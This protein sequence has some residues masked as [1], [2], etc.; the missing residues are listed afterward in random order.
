MLYVKKSSAE[1]DILQF[2]AK[3]CGLSEYEICENDSEQIWC[4]KPVMK[5]GKNDYVAS[6]PSI[7]RHIAKSNGFRNLLG[8][9]GTESRSIRRR[10][11]KPANISLVR[12]YRLVR[13][14]LSGLD[15]IHNLFI[16]N[17]KNH[18]ILGTTKTCLETP[19]KFKCCLGAVMKTPAE[20]SSR[21]RLIQE[22]LTKY[23]TDISKVILGV[24]DLEQI[25]AGPIVQ[26]NLDKYQRLLLKEE[27]Q[28]NR[29]RNSDGEL[30]SNSIRKR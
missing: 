1:A 14:Y 7:L 18:D 5:I 20:F 6:L 3:F 21:T 15:F 13:L 28:L 19:K 9:K 8:T 12:F 27:Q 30:Q 17:C 25:L 23:N 11:L 24:E 22:Y 2:V 10:N 29:K 26:H 4:E 16:F